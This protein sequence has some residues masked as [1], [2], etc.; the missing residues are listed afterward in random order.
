MFTIWIA[1]EKYSMK[2]ASGSD[3]AATVARVIASRG[4]G[5]F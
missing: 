2:R 1:M 3:M 5:L 4:G